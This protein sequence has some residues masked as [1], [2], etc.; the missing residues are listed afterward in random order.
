MQTC[1]SSGLR[2]AT[3]QDE[4]EKI[5]RQLSLPYTNAVVN[6]SNSKDCQ[7]QQSY[8]CSYVTTVNEG[9]RDGLRWNPNCNDERLNHNDEQ[10]D[11][12]LNLC[13]EGT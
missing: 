2:M 12:I 8:R 9:H 13:I 3:N 11:R 4:C 10:H 5:A 6:E 1:R 7:N